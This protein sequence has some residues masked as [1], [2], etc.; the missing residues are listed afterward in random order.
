MEK[1]N[2]VIGTFFSTIGTP[3]LATLSRADPGIESVKSNLVIGDNWGAEQFRDVQ[4]CLDS[5]ACAILGDRIDI[6]LLRSFLLG[7]EEFIIRIVE[8]PM[9][10]EHESF[11]E[12]ILAINHLTEELKAR[13]DFATL[14]PAD[15]H[16]L[17]IDI[18]R[19]YALLIPEWL[20]YMSYLKDH[21]PYLF[22][23]AMR[24][25]PFDDSASVIVKA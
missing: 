23:L 7:S 12:L 21:Y 25:N 11:T 8:N 20:K 6:E 2:L 4:D 16:H 3:L 1:L 14:P 5:H 22:N 15:L 17:S 9:I 10:F 13:G 18:Q 19:V 24:T